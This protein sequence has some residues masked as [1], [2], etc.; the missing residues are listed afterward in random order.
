MCTR[1]VLS[2]RSGSSTSCLQWIIYKYW[3]IFY[4]IH[5]DQSWSCHDS[6]P[7]MVQGWIYLRYSG[8]V[9][10]VI[11]YI[12]TVGWSGIDTLGVAGDVP[13]ALFESKL[14]WGTW[15][16]SYDCS[17]SC[18]VISLY[19][20]L[21]FWNIIQASLGSLWLSLFL[22]RLETLMNP[23]LLFFLC[24]SWDYLETFTRFSTAQQ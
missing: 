15:I 13:V 12:C 17:V 11:G 8:T 14:T 5:W 16:S 10:T 21:I 20:W 23:V 2:L 3:P 6:K 19:I 9:V 18:F 4:M 7:G 24:L 1:R 22:L